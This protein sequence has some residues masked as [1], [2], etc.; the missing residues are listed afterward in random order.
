MKETKIQK[1]TV[2]RRIK[3]LTLMQIGNSLRDLRAGDKK[4]MLGF[5]MLR[6]LIVAVVTAALTGIF[7]ALGMFFQLS[8]SRDML[9][10]ILFITQLISIISCL[11]GMMLILFSSKENTMLLAFPCK[12]SEIFVSKMLVFA[13]DE[14]KKSVYFL[15]P[16]L[17]GFGLN[18]NVGVGYFLQIPLHWLMLCLFPVFI[19]ST[20][21]IPAIYIKRFM[22]KN[23]W[24]YAILLIVGICTGFYL[25]H[26]V[27]SQIETPINLVAKYGEFIANVKATFVAIN[28]YAFFYNFMVD[29]AFGKMVYLYLPL[30][31]FILCSFCGLCF[32]LAMP[33]YFGAAS[34]VAENSSM[35]KHTMKKTGK[36][37]LFMTFFRKEIKILVR[38]SQS[39]S[40]LVTVIFLFPVIVYVFN[41]ILAAIRT[42]LLG[43]YMTIAFNLMISLSLLGSYNANSAASLSMEGSEFAVLKTA[44]SNTSVIAW[45]KV[46]V[47][48]IVNLCSLIMM[49]IMLSLT[50][51]LGTVDIALTVAAIFFVSIGQVAWGFQM[52]VRNP[53]INDYATKGDAVTDNKNVA[54]SIVMSFLVSTLLGILGLIILM[55]A[56]VY[57]WLRLLGIAIGFMVARLYLLRSNLGVYFDDIQG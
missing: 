29:A 27:L 5:V 18:A 10:T 54:K 55:D 53:R 14:L 4:K 22:Q 12:H 36:T 33:F 1:N 7:W 51:R 21:S 20:L 24:L 42:S 17:I 6:I 50:T 38:N 3:Y 43:K 40:S 37:S 34:S 35:K 9:V 8:P 44:P 46:V 23:I 16:L 30:L 19:G 41:F 15:I 13:L 28:R 26:S 52:D 25:I 2:W 56:Y 48:G 32:L 49:A 11:S 31:L 39:V 57:G 45:A 47:T